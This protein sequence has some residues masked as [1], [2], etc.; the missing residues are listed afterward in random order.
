[1]QSRGVALNRSIVSLF[2]VMRGKTRKMETD[3]NK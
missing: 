1:M 2:W 3:R